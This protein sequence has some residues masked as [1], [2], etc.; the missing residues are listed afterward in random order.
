MTCPL[1]KNKNGNYEVEVINGF[2]SPGWKICGMELL[3]G[4]KSLQKAF[5]VLITA[6]PCIGILGFKPVEVVLS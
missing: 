4:I 6:F 2:N 5:C 3:P 1:M